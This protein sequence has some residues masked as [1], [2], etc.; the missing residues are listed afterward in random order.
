MRTL[1]GSTLLVVFGLFAA[2]SGCGASNGTPSTVRPDKPD[3]S[4]GGDGTGGSGGNSGSGAT[5]GGLIVGESGSGN[6]DGCPSTCEALNANCGFVTDTR[7]TGVIECGTC[8]D[9]TFCGGDGPSRCG[10]NSSGDGGACSGPS[11]QTCTPQT[12]ADQGFSCGPAGDTCGGKLDCGPNTCAIPG[13]TC[14]GGSKPGNCGCTGVC[15]QIPDCSAAPI[16]TTSLSGYVFDPAGV[17]ALYNVFVY[18]AN[19][20]DD[21]ELLTFKPGVS[22]DV[23]GATA[24]GSPLVSDDKGSAG[25]YTDTA[26]HF[27]LNNVPVGKA[28]TVVIQLGRWRRVFKV[29]ID[30]P[31]DENKKPLSTFWMPSTKAQGNIPLIAMV[32]GKSD[33]LE[34][35]LK[36]I[37]I[38]P[39]EFTNPAD[40]GRVQFYLG[41]DAGASVKNWGQRIDAN[42]PVQSVLFGNDA[43]S[44]PVI[45]GYDMTL[46]ACQGVRPTQSPADLAT[47]RTYAASGGRVFVSHYNAKW[48]ET[49]NANLAQ[50]GVAD[51]WSE[52]AKWHYDEG[53]RIDGATTIGKID[54]MSNPKAMAFQAWLENVGAS[55]A[56]S[57]TMNVSYVNHSTDGVAGQTQQWLYRDGAGTYAGTNVPLHFTYSTPV[58]RTQD[59]T[60]NP[61]V[62]QCGRVLFS[63][64]HVK[65]AHEFDQTFPSKC[66]TAP[67]TPQEK[68]LEFMLFD[69]GSCVPP[70]KACVPLTM[71][72]A[73]SD[74]G[75][76]PDGCGGLISCGVCPSGESC[77]VGNPPV[78]N[79]CGKGT[80]TCTPKTCAAQNLE[81]GPAADG[82]G[83]KIDSCG[84]C[85][86]GELCIQGR[87]AHVN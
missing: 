10:T 87:C 76:A 23:C 19:N 14:G 7:C 59:L 6:S 72:P 82:C 36:K 3:S 57:G 81:C 80:Q 54:M 12:C 67:M 66:D 22:C 68:L 50:P 25:T 48:L 65:D 75:Y 64:F 46:L 28:I 61:P 77:G 62:V 27:M 52:A 16:K 73:G 70:G 13:W 69:L 8:P 60:A 71:C 39:T 5:S 41:S 53:D 74:C 11:C 79:K 1:L 37:G 29:D 4:T 30:T 40:G 15:S 47:L 2:A 34:C 31:C 24:A 86:A 43:S 21:P 83:A 38:D 84:L 78:P 9:G 17:N 56:G 45:N 55:T 33:S 85:D 26:G 20:P 42:T 63:D 58:N 35:T 51:N 44:K 18:V 49:N 32:T